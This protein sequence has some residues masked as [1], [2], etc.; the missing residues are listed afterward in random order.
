MVTSLAPTGDGNPQGNEIL[1]AV[2]VP[3]VERPEES[4]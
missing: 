2:V 4:P 3:T 1:V